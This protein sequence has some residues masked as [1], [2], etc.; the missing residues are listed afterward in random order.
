MSTTDH[1]PTVFS[2]GMIIYELL[3]LLEPYEDCQSMAEMSSKILDGIRPTIPPELKSEKFAQYHP[4]IDLYMRCTDFDPD[5]RPVMSDLV[6]IFRDM[7]IAPPPLPESGADGVEGGIASASSSS[8]RSTSPRPIVPSLEITST[9]VDSSSGGGA[10][11]DGGADEVAGEVS[12]GSSA[13]SSPRTPPVAP[14]RSPPILPRPSN[15]S[16]A[17]SPSPSPSASPHTSPRRYPDHAPPSPRQTKR[18]S[19]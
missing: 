19:A 12:Q 14:R 17:A 5:L 16:P 9:Q 15:C 6:A 3:T 4:F 10:S 8:S 7:P 13:P 2:F 18:G 1:F 11:A